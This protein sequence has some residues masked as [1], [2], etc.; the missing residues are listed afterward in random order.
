MPRNLVRSIPSRLLPAAIAVA[1]AVTTVGVAH[2]A[3]ADMGWPTRLTNA[4][5][6]ELG[7][8]G[9][10]AAVEMLRDNGFLDAQGLMR[11]DYPVV[12]GGK[13]RSLAEV[14]ELLTAQKLDL[15]QEAVVDGTPIALADLKHI[16]A[17][18]DAVE[19]ATTTGSTKS[20][21]TPSHT[22]A[23]TSLV[24]QLQ[25]GK[26]HSVDAATTGDQAAADWGGGKYQPQDVLVKPLRATIGL[27]PDSEQAVE[28]TLSRRVDHPVSVD[29][30]LVDGSARH[31]VHYERG[32]GGVR[33]QW[34]SDNLSG[35]MTFQAN[36]TRVWMV[37]KGLGNNSTTDREE[38]RANG[39]RTFLIYLYNVQGGRFDN[40]KYAN[41]I[42]G[43]VG[44]WWA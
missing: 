12:I 22:A 1:L 35:T 39:L 38:N 7:T 31:G 10:T 34:N 9:A 14:R 8:A 44:S 41:T 25:R 16:L 6:P 24:S 30:R 3:H 32:S 20:L 42:T 21:I 26:V 23:F 33:D 5:A 11:T 40:G 36:E 13:T 29:F 43:T 2:G 4:L 19:A 37:V 27:S 28:L 18:T 17:V 15:T